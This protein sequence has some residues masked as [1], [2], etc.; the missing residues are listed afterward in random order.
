MTNLSHSIVAKIG[1]ILF[2][3]YSMLG[4]N[5]HYQSPLGIQAPPTEIVA[6]STPPTVKKEDKPTIARNTTQLPY[7]KIIAPEFKQ[8]PVK[9]IKNLTT[10]P[11]PQPVTT[12]PLTT[13]QNNDF[14]VNIF[15]TIRNG[16]TIEYVTGSG[17][18]IDP[19]GVI[20]TNSH[21]AQYVL[22]ADYLNDSNR[23]CVART[24]S[25][26]KNTYNIKV[27][28]ISSAWIK[29]NIKTIS[30]AA[31]QGTGQSDYAFLYITGYSDKTQ[32]S[33][34]PYMSIS[35]D[36]L[37]VG[38]QLK[39]YGYPAGA[40]SGNYVKNSLSKVTDTTTVSNIYD[41]SGDSTTD[42]I[43]AHSDTIAERGSSGGPIIENN[44]IQGIITTSLQD[45]SGGKS[46]S[47]ITG[48]YINRDLQ[49]EA[50][51]SLSSLLIGDL[52][53]KSASFENSTG[54]SLARDLISNNP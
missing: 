49:N 26:A 46:F 16:N 21:V 8:L 15:C 27:M 40:A 22:L 2:G 28:Y 5:I 7:L 10:T 36:N 35:T 52:N 23:N 24:G 31:P 25:P 51:V 42:L 6:S 43:I 34:Y 37:N 9:E 41:F 38:D 29:N 12:P 33:S 13:N 14:V 19:K 45:G 30:E 54:F 32:P 39:V 53:K 18:I 50:G 47:A 48:E 11:T 3:I 44:S 4:W 1:T 20:I 17:A